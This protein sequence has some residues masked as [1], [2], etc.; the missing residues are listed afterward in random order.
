M[1]FAGNVGGATLKIR[2]MATTP[3]RPVVIAIVEVMHSASKSS[4][5]G[6]KSRDILPF[7]YLLPDY[8]EPLSASRTS[9]TREYYEL[10][11][12]H[13]DPDLQLAHP[14]CYHRVL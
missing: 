12:F 10:A 9:L 1:F 11:V 4:V 5:V 2:N 3:P 6:A 13:V 14:K 8:Q 7:K